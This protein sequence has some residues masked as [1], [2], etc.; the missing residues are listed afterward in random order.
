MDQLRETP[1]IQPNQ[2]PR[3]TF[4]YQPTG[5]HGSTIASVPSPNG[6][7]LMSIG[8]RPNF[9]ATA[10]HVMAALIQSDKEG[11]RTFS[12]IAKDAVEATDAL[13]SEINAHFEQERKASVSNTKDL[14]NPGVDDGQGADVNSGDSHLS[15]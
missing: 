11:G 9:E 4:D 12:D 8:G 2:P 5:N 1:I 10:A 6:I 7:K 14:D 3:V 13:Y 15:D